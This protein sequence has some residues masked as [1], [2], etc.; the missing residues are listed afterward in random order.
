MKK[1]VLTC[2]VVGALLLILGISASQ[3]KNCQDIL[4]NNRYRC[5]FNDEVS[6]P[7]EQCIQFNS[8]TPTVSTK[9]DVDFNGID[10]G[11]TCKAK[12]KVAE[13]DFNASKEFL[14]VFFNDVAAAALEGKVSRNGKKIKDG[15]FSRP[16]GNSIVFKCELDPT[17][18]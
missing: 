12:G 6:F 8:S 15:F 13:P 2:S 18:P 7:F 4:D 9:F 16:E 1:S 5:Q 10:Y 11:C 3:A 14:C 17:C